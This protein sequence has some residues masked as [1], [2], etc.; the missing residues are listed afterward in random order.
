MNM[1]QEYKYARHVIAWK[2]FQ[3]KIIIN[4]FVVDMK[5]ET[6]VKCNAKKQISEVALTSKKV[7]G[8]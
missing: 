4:N 3:K 7:S 2:K 1:A 5:T 8:K 6:S